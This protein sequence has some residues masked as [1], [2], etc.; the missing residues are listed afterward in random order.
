ML[1]SSRCGAAPA[2]TIM[3][4]QIAVVRC[5]QKAHEHYRSNATQR[6]NHDELA[7]HG[8][9]T[10]RGAMVPGRPPA[11][12]SNSRAAW[13]LGASVTMILEIPASRLFAPAQAPYRTYVRCC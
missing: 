10:K 7:Q 9:S 8:Q 3:I 12:Y 13:T 2:I 4:D 6:C 11:S 5:G 1:P